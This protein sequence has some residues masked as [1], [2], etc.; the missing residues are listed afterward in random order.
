M[1][2]TARDP[3]ICDREW[4]EGEGDENLVIYSVVSS[5]P[6]AAAA[7]YAVG[8]C[9]KR[10]TRRFSGPQSDEKLEEINNVCQFPFETFCLFFFINLPP[11][12]SRISY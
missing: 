2:T 3:F 10:P 4:A 1:T 6:A 12:S 9:P 5:D 8:K 7:A 11:R